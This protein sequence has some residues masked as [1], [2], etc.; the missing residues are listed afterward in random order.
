MFVSR[1]VAISLDPSK[2]HSSESKGQS[3]R[4]LTQGFRDTIHK[5]TMTSVACLSRIKDRSEK[6]LICFFN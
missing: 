3:R 5:L 2:K 6:G 4:N 1:Y